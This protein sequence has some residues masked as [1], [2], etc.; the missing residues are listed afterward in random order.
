LIGISFFSYTKLASMKKFVFVLLV[1][2]VLVSQCFATREKFYI[3]EE[4]FLSG[5][6]AKARGMY[7]Q[8]DTSKLSDYELQLLRYRVAILSPIKE[9]IQALS[10]SNLPEAV[11]LRDFL[12]SYLYGGYKNVD[13][14]INTQG[15]EVVF[16]ALSSLD[17]TKVENI[18]TLLTL[19]LYYSLS[20]LKIP[21]YIDTKISESDEFTK[22]KNLFVE[23]LAYRNLGEDAKSKE[24][25]E[26]IRKEYPNSFFAYMLNETSSAFST[27]ASST[28]ASSTNT[29][30]KNTSSSSASSTS[31]LSTSA[32]YYLT[33]QRIKISDE[34]LEDMRKEVNF[35]GYRL[36][37]SDDRVY[38]GPF[39]DKEKAIDF[40]KN[41]SAKYR[42]EMSLVRVSTK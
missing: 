26:K 3:A 13:D 33:F 28:S 32:G 38:I 30:S 5:G 27:S 41:I 12:N 15:E 6:Y 14:M 10:N 29:L 4:M 24:I 36:D 19:K 25:L 7:K 23:Y 42:V 37:I 40:G 1:V 2:F 9:G 35:S 11:Y 22:L 21:K 18:D 16:A 34:A 8:V 20:N 39:G 17:I 31:T